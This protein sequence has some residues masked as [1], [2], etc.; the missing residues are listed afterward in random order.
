MAYGS[1]NGGN[2]TLIA[3]KPTDQDKD[4]KPIS[5]R[6]VGKVKVDGV[7]KELEVDKP[8]TRV[9][10]DITKVETV[11][12]TPKDYDPYNSLKL[13]L[14]DAKAEEVYLLDLRFNMKTR[15][16]F[17]ALAA[18]EAYNK[19]EISI[20]T[21]K[22]GKTAFG[23]RQNGADVKWKYKFEDLP[24]VHEIKDK[25]GKV[26]GYDSDEVDEFMKNEL[27]ELSERVKNHPKVDDVPADN[28]N[29]AEDTADDLD[30]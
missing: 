8:V 15:G 24:K 30:F 9:A 14:R 7:W 6:F 28:E 27:N 21:N 19:V 26:K 17:N 1:S 20:Y 16:L 11:E 22:K 5:P 3:F 4:K 13:F 2:D 29:T 23:L 18:L 10:G 25:K 12:N